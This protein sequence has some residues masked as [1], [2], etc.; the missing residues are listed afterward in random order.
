MDEE[1]IDFEQLVDSPRLPSEKLK[2]GQKDD[3]FE[4]DLNAFNNSEE[5]EDDQLG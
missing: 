5:N 4:I 3:E 1:N 2:S